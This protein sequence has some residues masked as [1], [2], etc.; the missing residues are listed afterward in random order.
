MAERT[1]R[2]LNP[3]VYFERRAAAHEPQ[4]RFKG[5][6]AAQ[7]SA[8]KRTLLPKVLATLGHAPKKVPPR[9]ELV[10]EWRE[11]GL[12]KQKWLIDVQENLSTP[13]LLFRPDNLRRGEKR[14][15]ILCCHGHHPAAKH[16]VMGIATEG[17]PIDPDRVFGLEMAQ[18]GFVTYAIDWLGFGDRAYEAKP[19]FYAGLHGRDRCNIMY[20]CAT[21]LGTTVLASNLHDAASATD[22]VCGQP[23]VDEGRLG[24]MGVSLGG[25]MTTW[26]SLYDKRIKAADV[27]CYNGPFYNIAY[28]TYNVCGSQITPGLY[29]LCDIAELQ[30]LIAPKP[31]LIEI[32]IHDTCFKSDHTIPQ[33]HD[34]QKIYRAAG[35]ADNLELD[36]FGGEHG[37][38]GNKSLPFFRKHLKADWPQ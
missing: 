26:V 29:D 9:A 2:N 14:P 3:Q 23:H 13:L 28:S 15:A 36:L 35:A 37:W 22:F 38:G 27:I 24:V 31:L 33:F 20:N 25:T 8:W 21:L 34:T 5:K 12:V 32:G 7:Y 19:H 10:A 6:T 16:S 17:Q 1:K 30:G 11:D 18:A 4:Y